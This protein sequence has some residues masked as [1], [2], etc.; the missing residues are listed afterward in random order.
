[1]LQLQGQSPGPP[2]LID[3][4]LHIVKDESLEIAHLTS[5]NSENALASG[6]KDPDPPYYCLRS[7][8]SKD[9]AGSNGRG[10][11]AFSTIIILFSNFSRV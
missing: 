8:T 6:S 4:I 11:R 2:P 9:S 3:V 7:A 5:R 1:M 10:W